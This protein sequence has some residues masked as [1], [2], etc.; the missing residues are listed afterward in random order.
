M[1]KSN[2]INL[3]IVLATDQFNVQILLLQ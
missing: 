3:S 1:F 2:F